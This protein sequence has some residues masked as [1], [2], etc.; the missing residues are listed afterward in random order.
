M[1]VEIINVGTELLL[2]EIVNTNAATILKMCKELGIDV[3]HQS[4]VGDNPERLL[5]CFDIAFQRGADCIITTGGLGPTQDDL[6]KELSAKYLGLEMQVNEIEVKKVEA[7][8][9][10]L[11]NSKEIASAN[12]KQANFAKDCIILE[13]EVG[14]ANCCVASNNGKM[15]INLPGPPKELNYVIEHSLIPFL[16]PYAK[17]TLFSYDY[18][19]MGIG[20]SRLE[21]ILHDIIKS[22]EDVSI[23]LYASEE[24]V[25]I[26]LACKAFNQSEADKK[27][28]TTK[29]VIQPY[30]KEYILDTMNIRKTVYDMMPNYYI[31]Y[32]DDFRLPSD[33]Y[34]GANYDENAKLCISFR[35]EHFDVGDR[36]YVTI[37]DETNSD[38]SSIS[39]LKDANLSMNKI[40]SKICMS[41]YL[42]L[43]SNVPTTK[44]TMKS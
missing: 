12:Y 29:D 38:T 2:G 3:Y 17:E 35:I 28:E 9:G 31:R 26:R 43:Q 16:K 27:M 19:T 22:Q 25:R 30:I 20:E 24:N 32:E 5:S 34:L 7:K 41:M 11:S 23:A 36:I 14:T 44:S 21:D 8:C 15:I 18:V 6:S 37:S 1:I 33:F 39:L 42:F 13:N 4:V 10:F 40:T